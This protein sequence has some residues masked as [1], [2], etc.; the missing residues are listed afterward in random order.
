MCVTTPCDSSTRAEWE[1]A[2]PAMIAA[3]VDN[4]HDRRLRRK[5]PPTPTP[6]TE[7]AV[8]R[9]LSGRP[10]AAAYQFAAAEATRQYAMAIAW[11]SQ[12]AQSTSP[13]STP[14]GEAWCAQP[15]IGCRGG[16]GWSDWPS[17]K[18]N[19]YVEWRT[20]KFRE[21]VQHYRDNPDEEAVEGIILVLSVRGG[22]KRGEVP[23]KPTG[24]TTT[25]KL[26]DALR[27]GQEVAQFHGNKLEPS[28]ARNY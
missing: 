2:R 12:T 8:R 22:G 3:L 20:D 15:L 19:E 5:I 1:A 13:A 23:P 10:A 11:T 7:A 27:W 21:S 4:V 25:R 17:D 24:T 14:E 18:L 28:R 6:P 26:G 9:A 16:D